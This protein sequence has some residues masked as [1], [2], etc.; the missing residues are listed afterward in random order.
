MPGSPIS[1]SELGKDYFQFSFLETIGVAVTGRAAA[2][3]VVVALDGV[4]LDVPRGSFVGMLGKN[5]SGKSTLLRLLSGIAYP[6]RG[7][8]AISGNLSV[9]ME[10]AQL[11]PLGLTGRQFVERYLDLHAAERKRFAAFHDQAIVFSEL[12][13]YYDLPV[14]TYSDGM[15]SRLFFAALTLVPSDIYLIDEMLS[16]GD[17]YFQAKCWEFL[18]NRINDGAS[19]LL[20][21]HDWAT[22]M[23]LCESSY[24]IDKGHIV[25]YGRTKDI[26]ARYL[27][28]PQMETGT[29]GIDG[30]SVLEHPQPGNDFTFTVEYN[31]NADCT[32]AVFYS[33]ERFDPVWGWQILF[34]EENVPVPD[35]PGRHLVEFTVPAL[36]LAP[37]EYSLNI[38]L[39]EPYDPMTSRS[40]ARLYDAR[41]WRHGNEVSFEVVGTPLPCL[42][43]VDVASKIERLGDG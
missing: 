20:V 33:V 26:V 41:R 3:S 29:A 21:T 30:V 10:L 5:G 38:S 42:L 43:D 2:G 25:G 35:A 14:Y 4:T 39:A 1:C 31:V 7:Q 17:R 6:S 8:V 15:R 34:M 36:P 37:D 27:P 24:L 16:V 12:G 11:G 9:A 13:K 18:R 32:C 22:I 28:S 40:T 23:G 19:G